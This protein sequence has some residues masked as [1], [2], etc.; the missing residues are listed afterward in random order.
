MI[1]Q[2]VQATPR[3][4]CPVCQQPLTPDNSYQAHR[5]G[6]VRCSP[7]DPKAIHLSCIQSEPSRLWG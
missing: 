3:H 2:P 1:Q 5:M 7:E 6:I 4:E